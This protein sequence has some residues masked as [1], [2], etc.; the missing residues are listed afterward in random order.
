[1]KRMLI[2][3]L[4]A[5]E[6]RIAILK[7]DVLDEFYIEREGE[8]HH[9]GNIYK[10]RVINVEPSLQAAFVDFGQSRNGFLHISEVRPNALGLSALPGARREFG[11]DTPIQ[12]VLKPGQE[13]VVQVV[14]EEIGQK[15]CFLTTYLSIPGRYLVL[16]P[17]VARCGVSRKII[18]EEE[19]VRLKAVMRD[20]SPPRG[21]GFILRTAGQDRAKIDLQRD[22]RYLLRL[23]S[24]ICRRLDADPAPACLYSESDLVIRTI[25]DLFTEDM[26]EILIDSEP[27]SERARDFLRAVMPRFV[28]RIR[29]Y[30]EPEPLFHRHRIEM[31][32]EKISERRVN[33]VSGGSIVIERTE[34]LISVDVNSGK[35][36][37]GKDPEDMALR[38]NLEAASE[39]A[40]QL[41]LRDLGGV[42][43]C[44][45]IDLRQESHCRQVERTLLEGLRTD[46]ARTKMLR[47]SRFGIIE[48]TRQR[49]RSSVS[50]LLY[51]PCST[52]AGSGQVKTV[53]SMSLYVLRYIRRAAARGEGDRLT[54]QVHPAVASY[55]L[56]RKRPELLSLETATS[57]RISIEAD[58][59]YGVEEF[60]NQKPE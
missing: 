45:F 17:G 27:V 38:T 23:W 26:E 34:A 11:P 43:V 18:D 10:A 59:S 36:T 9:V 8:N 15:G 41:R 30:A 24:S 5:E 29:T 55:L 13:L 39:I 54:V 56:N 4:D 16:M 7:K 58:P 20:L 44:D 53:E 51:E 35:F 6:T 3:V 47:M 19:R 2:N 32:I 21:L 31:E 40:R 33:L 57:K 12:Q 1:M 25:R 48:I 50:S 14:K 49:V 52:C 28:S 22:L 37:E 42:V 46:R 60:K